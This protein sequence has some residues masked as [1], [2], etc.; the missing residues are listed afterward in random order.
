MNWKTSE[1][2]NRNRFSKMKDFFISIRA[3]FNDLE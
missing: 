2:F 3:I 1:A